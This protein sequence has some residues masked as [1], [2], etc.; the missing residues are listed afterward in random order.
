[1]DFFTGRENSPISYT[2]YFF[3]IAGLLIWFVNIDSD[4]ILSVVF[5]MV[6]CVL[7]LGEISKG[8]FIFFSEW[9]HLLSVFKIFRLAHSLRLTHIRVVWIW[10]ICLR[11][12]TSQGC[13]FLSPAPEAVPSFLGSSFIHTLYDFWFPQDS[14]A[15][16]SFFVSC[17]LK[18]L[19]HVNIKTITSCLHLI[20]IALQYTFIPHLLY[21][22]LYF[23]FELMD[24]NC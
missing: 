23:S 16:G 1:M 4:L 8:S 2:C 12:L 13:F 20:W 17:F 3:L 19:F 21:T 11:I 7:G 9:D 6:P 5:V 22:R 24:C 18:S 14:L 10:Y 15:S